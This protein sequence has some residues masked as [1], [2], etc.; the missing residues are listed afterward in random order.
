MVA[1]LEIYNNG[2]NIQEKYDIPMWALVLGGMG[3]VAGIILLGKRTIETVGAKITSLT[4]SK[5]FAT[6]MGAAVAIMLSSTLE[7]PVSTSH[8]LIGSVIGVGLV[9]KFSANGKADIT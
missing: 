5:S 1:V 8:C 6:Q 4:P 2:G 9:Q 7:L 3:F